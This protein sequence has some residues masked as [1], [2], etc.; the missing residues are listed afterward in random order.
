MA[1]ST[2]V[3]SQ[4]TDAVTQSNLTVVGDAPAVSLATIYQNL[5]HASVLA[6]QNA[7]Q[8]QQNTW[9]VQMAVTAKLVKQILSDDPLPMGDPLYDLFDDFGD[10]DLDDDDGEGA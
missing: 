9:T 10:D 6:M 1:D 5:A 2:S 4:I 3:N 7:V 8:Q